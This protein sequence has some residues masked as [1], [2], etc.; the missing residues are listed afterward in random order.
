M[1]SS[2]TF[3]S[4]TGFLE[5]LSLSS[6]SFSL[7]YCHEHAI[8]VFVTVPGERWEV[9]FFADGEVEVEKFVSGGEIHDALAI[10]ELIKRFSD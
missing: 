9:E 4:L 5:R 8:M 3:S 1:N 6:I 7:G 10:D 2:S